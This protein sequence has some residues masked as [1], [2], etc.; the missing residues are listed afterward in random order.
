[1][2][3]FAWY[4]N[5]WRV[6]GGIS[7]SVTVGRILN[8]RLFALSI[9]GDMFQCVREGFL[10]IWRYLSTVNVFFPLLICYCVSLSLY[11]SFLI[12]SAAIILSFETVLFCSFGMFTTLPYTARDLVILDQIISPSA[13]P[14]QPFS[15]VDYM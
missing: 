9:S 1:M 5:F 6:V 7:E 14:F 2:C 10:A 11:Q 15:L 3:W 8:A 12:L 4:S 13:L